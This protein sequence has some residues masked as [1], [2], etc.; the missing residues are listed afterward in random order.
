[1]KRSVFETALGALVLVVAGLF[2]YYGM[3][4][5]NVGTMPDAYQITAE[6]SGIGGLKDGDNVNVSGV[7]IG[8]IAGVELDPQTYLARVT[9][10]IR[11][12][13][14]LPSDTT[15]V[16][17]SESLLGGR[18]L[19]L[20][21][22][23]ADDVIEPGGKVEYT[24]APQNLEELLGKFIFSAQNSSNSSKEPAAAAAPAANP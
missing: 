23:G 20:E 14:R 7:K 21:P 18:Y 11:Q 24:Q 17:S 3:S 6:F 19:A 8:T 5:A 13:V 2:L 10:N 9:M 1:M 4:K 12:D 15:A 16:I 22:G